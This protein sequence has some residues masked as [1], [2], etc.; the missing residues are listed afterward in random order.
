MSATDFTAR[1]LTDLRTADAER[2][3]EQRR[4]DAER[5]SA[6]RPVAPS[7]AGFAALLASV[8]HDHRPAAAR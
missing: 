3:L 4:R 6:A 2:R 5:R 8:L 7:R 1:I